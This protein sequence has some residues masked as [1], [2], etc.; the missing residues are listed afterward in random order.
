MEQ[1]GTPELGAR[2]LA[3]QPDGHVGAPSPAPAAGPK[4]QAG[5][6][7]ADVDDELV[8][9][10]A[11]LRLVDANPETLVDERRTEGHPEQFGRRGAP[12]PRNSP[13]YFGFYAALGVLLAWFL[14]RAVAGIRSVLVLLVVSMFLAVGLNPLVERLIRAGLRR[15][16]AVLV[17]FGGAI[18]AFAAFGAAIVPPVVEQTQTFAGNLPTYVEGL[19]RSETIRRINED[20]GVLDNAQTY[21]STG[22]LGTRLF[23]GLLGVGKLVANALFSLL[24]VLIL[25]LYFLASLPNIKREIYNLVPS[26]RRQRVSLLG[27]EILLRIGGYVSGAF[28]VGLIAAVSSFVFLLIVGMPYP[29]ALA[30]LTGVL[31]LVPMVG[32]TVAMVV[33]GA[34]GFFQSL[35]VGVACLVY[36]LVYQQV[37]NYVIYPRVMRRSVDVPAAVTVIAALVGGSLL[38]VVGALLAIPTAAAVLLIVREV[39][40]PRQD[41]A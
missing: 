39:V 14:A 32:A 7:A 25:S 17:V 23:G 2:Q 1:R 38:G 11:S 12:L 20:Y 5:E 31:S 9:D 21:L 34:V 24:T 22:N 40:I 33:V 29:A 28:V 3:A 15:G 18:L 27:D 10:D 26:S 16:I 30:L 36:Y 4:A 37:E 41:A 8:E 19:Q 35:S 13:F 6:Q